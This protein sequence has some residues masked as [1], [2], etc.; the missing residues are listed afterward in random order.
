MPVKTPTPNLARSRR[1]APPAAAVDPESA[2]E[3][4]RPMRWV[5]D[6]FKRK[7]RVERRGA[8]IYVLLDPKPPAAAQK[9]EDAARDRRREALRMAQA[10]L[11]DLLD[12]H[13]DTRHV[14]PHL[15][16]VEQLLG[17]AGLRGLGSLPLPVLH[18]AL[19]QLESPIHD[20]PAAG[21]AELRRRMAGVIAVRL[22]GRPGVQAAAP[23]NLM[24][25]FHSE[26]RLEVSEASH[27]QF[28]ELER[29]WSGTLP[30]ALAV[31]AAANPNR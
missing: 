24:S 6:L 31:I 9:P 30:E 12:R 20:E 7:L 14:V 28:D 5:Q 3:S 13:A 29:S 1:P 4:S 22:G 21:L 10:D 27:S 17:R 25:D 16:H 11:R 18:K 8:Q 23:T 15:S 26:D 19:T 2:S